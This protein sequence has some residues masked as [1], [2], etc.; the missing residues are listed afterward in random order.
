MD[1]SV[2]WSVDWTAV[3]CK[4]L[5]IGGWQIAGGVSHA[6]QEY[7]PG[8][9]TW[10]ELPS[11]I[12]GRSH[13]AAVVFGGEVMVM[14]GCGSTPRPLRTVER[15]TRQSQCWEAMPSM[16]EALMWPQAFVVSR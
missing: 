6:V 10:Q 7:D 11:L 15:Y 14:G 9:R 5:V 2:D 16:T 4:L 8:S 1:W 13:P 3:C 12:G